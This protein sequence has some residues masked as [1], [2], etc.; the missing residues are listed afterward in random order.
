M[1]E[2]ETPEQPNR[3]FPNVRKVPGQIRRVP[4]GILRYIPEDVW[5]I[6]PKELARGAKRW[7]WI[8]AGHPAVHRQGGRLAAGW[9]VSH[10]EGPTAMVLASRQSRLDTETRSS[11]TGCIYGTIHTAVEMIPVLGDGLSIAEE[12][13]GR[14]I[15]GRY[16]DK[17]DRGI[18]L[19]TG[20]IP[21]VP[22]LPIRIVARNV[23]A[24]IEDEVA[25]RTE[26]RLG[27]PPQA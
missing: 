16:L 5:D 22:A 1:P 13:I 10:W 17:L 8:A 4:G 21:V 27:L 11:E 24:S 25:R 6:D 2:S 3:R 18:Y 12:L 7:G 26:D 20:L 19:A 23:R 14:E 15:G 9:I